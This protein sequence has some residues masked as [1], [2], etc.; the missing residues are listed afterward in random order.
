MFAVERKGER[1]KPVGHVS[2]GGKNP[3][4]FGI[5]PSGR[6]LVAANQDSANLV[7]FR[8]DGKTGVPKASG[9]TASVPKPVCVR[10]L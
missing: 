3:R 8:I 4:H 7:V 9:Q 6:W 2:T 10:F 5:D 1:L